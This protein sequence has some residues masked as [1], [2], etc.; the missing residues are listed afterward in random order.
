MTFLPTK[1][2]YLGFKMDKN[3]LHACES[4]VKAIVEAPVPQNVTQV[5]A[6]VGL[7]NY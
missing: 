3:G 4:K 6:F 7:V 2:E 1:I 5:K